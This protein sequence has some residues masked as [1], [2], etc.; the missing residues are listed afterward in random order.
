MRRQAL[1]PDKEP[2]AG[3]SFAWLTGL[4]D[5]HFSDAAI[6]NLRR[7]L[8]SGGTL[9][10]N[11]GLGLATFDAA[12]RRELGRLLPGSALKPI[13]ADHP[14]LAAGPFPI[15][16]VQ[17]TPAARAAEPQL[18]SPALEGIQINGDIRVIYSRLD[19]EAGW[20]GCEFP[21]MKGYEADTSIALGLDL[22]VYAATH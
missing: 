17:L 5:F 11:N 10:V 3:R 20:T 18:T 14:M 4:D 21:M 9:V 6:A 19:L 15:G 22:I 1:N 12:A 16:Q 2:L 7:F 8:D 13:P